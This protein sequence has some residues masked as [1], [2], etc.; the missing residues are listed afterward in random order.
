MPP[1]IDLSVTKG[2]APDPVDVGQ[3][4]TYTIVVTNAGP[5]TATGVVATDTLPIDFVSAVSASSTQGSCTVASPVVTCQIGTM[6]AGAKV[7]VTIVVKANKATG[8]T[9]ALNTVVVVGQQQAETTTNNNTAS[10]ETTIRGPFKPPATCASMT[11]SKRT[12]TVGS[13]ARIKITVRATNGKPMK[14]VKVKVKGPGFVKT[15]KT[16]ANGVVFVTIAPKRPGITTF[17]VP[18]SGKCAKRVGIAGAFQP[19]VTGQA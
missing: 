11:I 14:N 18:S 12:I 16:N 2:D 5:S 8:A 17:T 3:N 4:I 10:A 19:P 1:A 6:N 15:V 7:T 13:T 9:K